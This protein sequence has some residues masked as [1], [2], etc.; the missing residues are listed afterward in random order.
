MR[1]SI[2][3][4]SYLFMKLMENIEPGDLVIV[5]N[6]NLK[7]DEIEEVPEKSIYLA[8]TKPKRAEPF[9]AAR[10]RLS[11]HYKP[12]EY[13]NYVAEFKEMNSAFDPDSASRE[14]H[15]EYSPN[16]SRYEVIK[17]KRNKNV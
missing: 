5:H 10:D 2:D 3:M 6:L 15:F 17:S 9:R 11:S 4:S 8:L 16:L 14:I 7:E 1:N 12:Q 13:L